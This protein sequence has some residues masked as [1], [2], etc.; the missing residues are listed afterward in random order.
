M[1]FLENCRARS[2]NQQKRIESHLCV[3]E[4]QKAEIYWLANIQ[5]LH[6]NKE[7]T[8]LKK[9]CR[10]NKSSPL[11]PLHPFLDAD[12]LIRVGGREQNSNRAYS[13]KHPVILHGSHP[14]TRV[15]IRSERLRL[16]HAGPTLLSCSLNRRFHILGSRKVVR[17][18]TR[19]CVTCR[20]IAAKPQSQMMG[21]LP[22]ERVTPD[23]IFD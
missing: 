3:V 1:R 22:I 12:D 9:G 15:I 7:I 13:T 20:R 23:L 16:L 17:S 5:R 21:Q 2:S 11:I 8:N 4:L 18:I 19:S 14:I 6:F 10:L